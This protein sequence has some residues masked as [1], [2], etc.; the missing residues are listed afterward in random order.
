[1]QSDQFSPASL[2]LALDPKIPYADTYSDRS[3]QAHLHLRL[4][5]GYLVGL[6]APPS[7]IIERSIM[8]KWRNRPSCKIYCICS[9]NDK[10][11]RKWF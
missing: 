6:N 8:Q 5:T 11:F 10:T 1:M 4:W 2:L 7:L 9:F 3:V